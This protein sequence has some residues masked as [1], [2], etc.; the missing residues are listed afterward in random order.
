MAVRVGLAITKHLAELME[1]ESGA[2]SEPG[3]GST[4][5]FTAKLKLATKQFE[6]QHS[7]APDPQPICIAP[8]LVSR[9]HSGSLILLVDDEPIDLEITKD[10]LELAGLRV[11]CAVDGL[12]AV[13]FVRD[14]RPSLVLMDM[15]MP[16]MDGLTATRLIRERHPKL[17]LPIIAMTAN[18]FDE[19][20]ERCR[21]AGWTISSPSRSNPNCCMSGLRSGLMPAISV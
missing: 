9:R 10:M 5:W 7:R 21:E 4:F 3:V 19:D 6:G 8:E 15:Q 17:R 20:R 16:E 2:V 13:N 14:K 12:Q 11:E 18:A 1:G